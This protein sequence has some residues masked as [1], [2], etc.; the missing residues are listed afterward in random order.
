MG[1]FNLFF[2]SNLDAQGGNPAIKK[3]YLDKF[4]KL[5][6]SNDFCNI[7]RVRNTKSKW[8]AFSQKYSS[9]FNKRRLD[10]MLISNTLQEFIIMTKT[11]T[12][13][14]TVHSPVLFS[15]SKKKKAVSEVK[16]FGNFIASF[17]PSTKMGTL[18]M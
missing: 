17:P 4:I 11:L 1:D 13:I 3:K 16:D 10:Y 6:E 12:P 18:E 2:D 14:S 9:G 15:L 7:W 8:F 5:K